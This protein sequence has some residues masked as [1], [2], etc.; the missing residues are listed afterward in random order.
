LLLGAQ[1]RAERKFGIP[2]SSLSQ[3]QKI[4]LS[5]QLLM[6][7]EA[8]T[9][10]MN[11]IGAPIEFEIQLGEAT[12]SVIQRLE[13]GGIIGSA[14]AFRDFLVYRGLDTTLQAGYYTLNSGMNVIEVALA[15]QDAT[16]SEV[17]FRILPGWRIEEIAQALT[18]SG[19]SI[20]PEMFLVAA[21]RPPESFPHA[22]ALP[23]YANLEGFIYPDSYRFRRDVPLDGFI[24]SVL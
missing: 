2:A 15:L 5:A 11:P 18:T 14:S 20:S 13:Q 16:P 8:L 1:Q 9:Q 6:Q 22:S 21:D 12:G 17:S 7:E 10:P 3:L 4:Y 19:I 23:S 24:D